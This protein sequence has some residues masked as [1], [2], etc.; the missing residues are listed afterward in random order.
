MTDLYLLGDEENLL[1]NAVALNVMELWVPSTDGSTER[2][3]ESVLKL[4]AVI[5][6]PIEG[7][8]TM[9]FMNRKESVHWVKKIY[10]QQH[11]ETIT[12]VFLYGVVVGFSLLFLCVHCIGR[13][14]KG[15]LRRR[16]KRLRR[17]MKRLRRRMKRLSSYDRN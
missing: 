15:N 7:K 16:M 3:N 17:R 1:I 14:L 10:L 5:T 13:P 4:L 6:C 11:V 12:Q 8:L 2:I 9:G